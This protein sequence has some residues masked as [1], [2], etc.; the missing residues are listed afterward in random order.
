MVVFVTV[1]Q[2][3]EPDGIGIDKEIVQ[4]ISSS[5]IQKQIVADHLSPVCRVV[6][7]VVP[8]ALPPLHNSPTFS[9]QQ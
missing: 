5:A 2:V 1:R 3:L 6:Q 9:A 8:R 7:R 4:V